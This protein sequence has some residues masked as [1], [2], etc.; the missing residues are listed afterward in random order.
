MREI[1]YEVLKKAAEGDMAAF[2]TIYRTASDYVYTI[3]FRI[4][5]NRESAEEVTQDVFLKVYHGLRN[6]HFRSAVKTWV[7]RITVN[8]AINA[9]R[10]ASKELERRAEFDETVLQK[11]TEEAVRGHIDKEE[12][13]ALVGRLLGSLSPEQRA[14]VVLRDIEGLSYREIADALKVN[15]NTV[16]SRLKRARFAL[17]RIRQKRG[18]SDEMR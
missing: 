12:S 4:V 11:P 15:I 13:E 18:D 5:G 9:L 1:P 14:C 8:T 7:Y 3:A 16:R 10:R 6:F 17:A 2:E